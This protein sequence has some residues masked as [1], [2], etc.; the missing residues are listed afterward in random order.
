MG[1]DNWDLTLE[2]MIKWENEIE[3]PV[4]RQAIE[5]NI[6]DTWSDPAEQEDPI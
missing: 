5:D 6:A 4:V 3:N 1:K 2:E